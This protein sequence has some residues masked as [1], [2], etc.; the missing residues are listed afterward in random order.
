MNSSFAKTVEADRTAIAELR[1]ECSN[2]KIYLVDGEYDVDCGTLYQ[3]YNSNSDKQYSQSSA[4]RSGKVRIGGFNLWHPGSQN[5]GYKDYKLIAK[6]INNSDIVGALELLPLVSLDAK[7]NREVVDA[8]NE[9][10]A[11]LRAL[12]KE[13]SQA[14]RNGDLDKVQ[15]LKAKITIV[16]DTISKAP[17]LYRSPG[18]LK[19]LSELRKLDSSWSLILSPRGDSAKPTHVKELTG[20]Y[21]RGRNV[22]PITNEHC[23]ETYSNVTAK[24][25]ACFPNLRASFM[26]RETSHVFSRR[27]LLASFKS[28]NFDFSI[29]TSHVVFTSPHPVEDREDMENILRPSFG[30]SDYK[31]LGVGLDSTNYAR[32]AEAKVLMEL[33]QKLKK[34]YKEKDI[35]YVGDMNLTADNPYWSNLLKETGEH[36]LLIDVE[37]SLSL[38]KENSRGVPTNAMASNYDHFILPKNGFLN[39]RKNNDDYDTSRLKYLE[40]YVYDYISENYIVRSKRI[41][42]QDKEVEQIYPEDEELG[43]SMVS[44]FDYQLTKTGERQMNKMLTKLKSELNKVYTIKKGE[45]V[46][47]DSKIEQRLNYFRDRVFLSQLSNNTFYRVYK[48]IISDH[49]PISMNCNNN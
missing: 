35:M 12:K 17:S 27:P 30:V 37:T 10:P 48:E 22:K 44:S 32:F 16:T 49:Y 43:E 46:K 6:I 2:N 31:E 21:Y 8:I 25:Y 19:V 40:G 3:H 26:G 4:I 34:N 23:Q 29:L 18:Y 28:G 42:D 24:K 7:N 5:S 14:N 38:A 47:D 9:G 45:I 36:E 20:F 33:M 41:K 1:E 11:E 13:L 39:C 15:I